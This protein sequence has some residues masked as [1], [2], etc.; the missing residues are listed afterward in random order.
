MEDVGPTN[1]VSGGDKEQLAHHIVPQDYIFRFRDKFCSI[2][3]NFACVFRH[4]SRE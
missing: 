4:F 3:D 1:T 2:L